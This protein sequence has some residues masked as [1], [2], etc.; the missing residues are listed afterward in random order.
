M[1]SRLAQITSTSPLALMAVFYG[2]LGYVS[3][4]LTDA[5]GAVAR[6]VSGRPEFRTSHKW[7]DW[8]FL[9]LCFVS[10]IAAIGIFFR[11]RW[12]KA[13]SLVAFGASGV[14]AM[15]VD[16]APESWRGVWFST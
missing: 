8:F 3:F 6:W 9:V 14:W 7:D 4:G 13:A 10:L 1:N 11:K 12:A 5:L 2:L 16:A 15:L